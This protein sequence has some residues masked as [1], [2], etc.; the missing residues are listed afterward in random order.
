MAVGIGDL[1]LACQAFE[2]A[3]AADN[4]HAEAHVNL[5][6]L[7]HRKVERAGALGGAKY[8]IGFGAALTERV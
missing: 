1:G 7:E 5:G 3:I 8:L 2:I 4:G 6:V